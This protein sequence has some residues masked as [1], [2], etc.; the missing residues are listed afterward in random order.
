METAS[1]PVF[2]AEL[3]VMCLPVSPHTWRARSNTVECQAQQAKRNWRTRRSS[4]CNDALYEF[5]VKRDQKAN[6]YKIAEFPRKLSY[7]SLF[8]MLS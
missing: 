2:S 1:L 7:A 4:E 8:L 5:S 6:Q 3:L